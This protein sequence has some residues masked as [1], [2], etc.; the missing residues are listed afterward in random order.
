MNDSIQNHVG[1]RNHEQE[2]QQRKHGCSERGKTIKKNESAD[3]DE[4]ERERLRRKR[5]V[6]ILWKRTAASE[7]MENHTAQRKANA[8][9][10]ARAR[11]RKYVLAFD[12]E[13][14]KGN[15]GNQYD[16]RAGFVPQGILNQRG[17][18]VVKNKTGKH[19]EREEAAVPSRVSREH[20]SR[21]G[22]HL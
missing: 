3:P 15:Q 6:S 11:D 10:Y 12:I 13:Q 16:V 5:P 17:Q 18:R 19:D 1:K 8:C 22:R 14:E 7:P 21:G 9:S 4:D 2:E 20:M